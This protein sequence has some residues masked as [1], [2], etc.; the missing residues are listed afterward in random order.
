[1]FTKKLITVMIAAFLLSLL[2][3]LNSAQAQTKSCPDP[4][5]IT[6]F[7]PIMQTYDPVDL[8]QYGPATSQSWCTLNPGSASTRDHL[9]TSSCPFTEFGTNST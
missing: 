9:L 4:R 1:M 2:M 7:R 6:T 8:M 3:F 5:L